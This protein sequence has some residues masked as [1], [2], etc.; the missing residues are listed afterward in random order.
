MDIGGLTVI[1]FPAPVEAIR[2]RFPVLEV[3]NLLFRFFVGSNEEVI[4][5]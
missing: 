1:Q 3:V 2:D 4:G 5:R